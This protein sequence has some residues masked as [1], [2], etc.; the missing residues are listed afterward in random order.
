MGR[1][2]VTL[3]DRFLQLPLR[4]LLDLLSDNFTKTRINLVLL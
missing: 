3:V 2:I 1:F 4:K